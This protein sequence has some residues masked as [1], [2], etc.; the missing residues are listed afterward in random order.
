MQSKG[1]IARGRLALPEMLAQ[2]EREADLED[3]YPVGTPGQALQGP[4][5]GGFISVVIILRTSAMGSPFVEAIP[6]ATPAT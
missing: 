1:I 3:E 5:P 4:V 6:A 2:F